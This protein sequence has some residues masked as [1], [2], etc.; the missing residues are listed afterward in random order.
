MNALTQDGLF[1]L[2]TAEH[3]WQSAV[4][5]RAAVVLDHA[6]SSTFHSGMTHFS[7]IACMVFWVLLFCKKLIMP[8]SSVL[9][10]SN[11]SIWT[12]PSFKFDP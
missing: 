6:L 2:P 11:L 4:R 3:M 7:T 5:N 9:C 8:M 1:L 12:G 10:S